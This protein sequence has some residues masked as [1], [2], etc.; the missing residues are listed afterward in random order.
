MAFGKG[1]DLKEVIDET[2]LDDDTV[3]DLVGEELEVFK[4]REAAG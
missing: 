3:L 1:Y 2:K 4:V